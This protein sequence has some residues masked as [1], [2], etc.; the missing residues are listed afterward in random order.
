MYYEIKNVYVS[1]LEARSKYDSKRTS[2]KQNSED[3]YNLI[4]N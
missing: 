4:K 2:V 3:G 1:C